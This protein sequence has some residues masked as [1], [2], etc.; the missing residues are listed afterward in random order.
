MPSGLE[1]S[2]LLPAHFALVTTLL[3]A[4]SGYVSSVVHLDLEQSVHLPTYD[5]DRI[6]S[7]RI[8]VIYILYCIVLS[9][10]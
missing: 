2:A 4:R 1:E 7:H 3:A 5:S 9:L 10:F 6:A 8:R